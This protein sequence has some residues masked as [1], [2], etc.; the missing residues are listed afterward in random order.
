VL[1][2]GIKTD[3][4]L[5]REDGRHAGA[6]PTGWCKAPPDDRLRIEPGIHD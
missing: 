4:I 6:M 3:L 5:R 2:S 1:C